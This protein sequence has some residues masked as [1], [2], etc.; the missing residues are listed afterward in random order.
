M[1]TERE[2]RLGGITLTLREGT[3]ERRRKGEEVV[4]E[5]M[6]LKR[7]AEEVGEDMTNREV[8][9]A[10]VIKAEG[11]TERDEDM[12]VM[13]KNTE[14]GTKEM[15]IN[16]V[17]DIQTKREDMKEMMTNIEDML[18]K[19]EDMNGTMTNIEDIPTERRREIGE[20]TRIGRE[21]E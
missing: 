8:T 4:E 19:R 20:G 15:V 17:V 2:W 5:G 16:K 14:E 12:T 18:T 6:N 3:T 13:K 9:I 7:G 21:R 11:T 1:I 10:M